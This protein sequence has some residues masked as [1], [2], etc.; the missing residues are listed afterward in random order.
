MNRP[1]QLT[2]DG[3][4]R[5]HKWLAQIDRAIALDTCHAAA[6]QSK[7]AKL[8]AHTTSDGLLT[9]WLGD[10]AEGLRMEIAAAERA[11]MNRRAAA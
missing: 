1:W 2:R 10:Y 6:L 5:A 7:R 4:A 8:I 11:V 3:M 9:M